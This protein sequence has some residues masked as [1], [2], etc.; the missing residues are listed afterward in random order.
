MSAGAAKIEVRWGGRGLS[1]VGTVVGQ[2]E[3]Y[4]AR[5]R[6][7]FYDTLR[8]FNELMPTSPFFALTATLS[9]QVFYD[10]VSPYSYLG[11]TALFKLA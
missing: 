6:S 4:F 11:V 1:I 8:R 2:R 3:V 9:P 7:L 5:A 10:I